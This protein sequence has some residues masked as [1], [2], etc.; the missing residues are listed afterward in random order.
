MTHQAHDNLG[1]ASRCKHRRVVT[2][3]S[4]LLLGAGAV[5]NS[6]PAFPQPGTEV[7]IIPQHEPQRGRSLTR[8]R[9]L[10]PPV[11][12]VPRHPQPL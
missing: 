10:V 7:Q 1:G 9:L 5:M 11:T 8:L 6:P 12:S 2:L 4:A 3:A